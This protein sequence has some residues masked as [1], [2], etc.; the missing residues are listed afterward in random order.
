[1]N[2]LNKDLTTIV[3]G[4]QDKK[5]HG[6][7]VLNLKRCGDTICNYLVICEGNTPTQVHAIAEGVGTAMRDKRDLRPLAVEGM[8]NCL[9]VAMDYADIMV[10]VFVPECRTFYDLDNLWE[11]ADAINIPDETN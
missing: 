8:R 11:D 10:H 3:D 6:I 7:R 5:G 2:W 4:I 9:W 1:M